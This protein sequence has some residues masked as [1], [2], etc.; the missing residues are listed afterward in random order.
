MTVRQFS[1]L[2]FFALLFLLLICGCADAS[3]GDEPETPVK[4]VDSVVLPD[5]TPE[6]LYAKAEGGDVTVRF[7]ASGKWSATV[8]ESQQV[9]NGYFS[10]HKGEAGLNEIVFTALANTTQAVRQTVLLVT[11]GRASLEITIEQ[12]SIDI[13]LPEEEE[14]RQF[15]IRLYN[16]TDGPHWRFRERWCTD[17]PLNQWG[18]SVKYSG[19]KLELWLTENYLKGTFDMSGCKALTYVKLTKNE[20][21]ELN[22]S[23]CPLLKEIEVTSNQL[24]KINI[25]NCPSLEKLSA[26]YNLLTDI[27]LTGH[28]AMRTIYLSS[29]RFTSVDLSPCTVLE[30]AAVDQNSLT[31]LKLPEIRSCLHSFFCYSNN[32]RTLNLSGS[33]QLALLNC[34]DNELTRLDISGCDKLDRLYCYE[35]KLPEID[36]SS[37]RSVLA[38]FYCYSNLLTELN[39]RGFKKLSQI[40]CSD[41]K[42]TRLD[43]SGCPDARW[44]LCSFNNISELVIDPEVNML[45]ILDITSNNLSSVDFAPFGH[46]ISFCE[47]Y[48]RDNP[49]FSEIPERVATMDVFEHDARFEYLPDGRYVDYGVG[50]WY[51]GEP[52]SGQHEPL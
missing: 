19:G 2:F 29:N 39:V 11:C 52:Q 7:V 44:I 42:L 22:V 12:P 34:G 48:C 30:T 32:L 43:L 1:E 9:G 40:H 45:N 26:G 37:Q 21:T 38:Q 41:N 23:D 33:P 51:P 25:S 13:Q 31:E 24:E 16:E 6:V 5:G 3:H 8:P 4:A 47:L 35:N 15:L 10:T 49:I 36:V 14:V 28:H 18:S 46:W 20:L 27:D 17:L 50:W